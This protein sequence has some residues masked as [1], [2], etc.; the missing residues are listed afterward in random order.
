VGGVQNSGSVHYKLDVYDSGIL[1]CYYP[2]KWPLIVGAVFSLIATLVTIIFY[3]IAN[4]A[5]TH[6]ANVVQMQTV[7]IGTTG[8]PIDNYQPAVPAPY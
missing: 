6:N 7:S 5:P 8:Y 3:N 4:Q 1:S 2:E